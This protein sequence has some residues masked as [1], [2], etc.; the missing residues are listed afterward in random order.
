MCNA[1]FACA[2]IAVISVNDNKLEKMAGEGD[3]RAA[4]LLN[5]TKQPVR[6][7]ATIQVAITL[8]RFLGSA[9]AADNFSEPMVD[10]LVRVG[11]G[12]SRKVLDTIAVIL[13]TILLSYV[14]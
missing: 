13:T 1:V 9:F 10:W 8:S 7:L 12:G 5:L 4:K 6:F 3:I 2:E 11:I 14:T